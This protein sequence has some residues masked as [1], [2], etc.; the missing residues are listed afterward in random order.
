MIYGNPTGDEK[1]F[2]KSFPGVKALDN[3]SFDVRAGK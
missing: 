2:Q 3:V 1:Y